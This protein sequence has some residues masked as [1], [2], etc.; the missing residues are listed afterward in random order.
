MHNLFPESFVLVIV[1]VALSAFRK[2]KF[3]TDARVYLIYLWLIKHYA[4]SIIPWQQKEFNLNFDHK[5]LKRE[6]P[7]LKMECEFL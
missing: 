2:K 7:S 6:I 4:C 5:M 3:K 1:L